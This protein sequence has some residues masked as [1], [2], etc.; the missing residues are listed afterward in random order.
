[1]HSDLKW[2]MVLCVAFFVSALVAMVIS[3][4]SVNQCRIQLA[5][6]QRTAEDIQRICH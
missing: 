1:M 4:W 3:D 5:Q 6:T 2:Y